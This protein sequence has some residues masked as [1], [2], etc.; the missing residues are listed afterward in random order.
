MDYDTLW[1]YLLRAAVGA[2]VIYVTLRFLIFRR[3]DFTVR[4]RRG[5]VEFRG[6]F[7]LS[8]RG[9]LAELLRE[10]NLEGPAK[11]MGVRRKSGLRVWFS[12]ALTAGQKQRIRNFLLTRR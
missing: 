9:A 3:A 1:L 8:Q 10:M 7:P 5:Q 6:S 4:Y 11:I 12:G 2:V